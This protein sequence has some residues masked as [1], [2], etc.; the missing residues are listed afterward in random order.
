MA[1]SWNNADAMALCNVIIK[2]KESMIKCPFCGGKRF[3]F[4]AEK[5]IGKCFQC[6][7]SADT[8]SYYAAT[9]N[10]SL[11]EARKEIEGRL[12]IVSN[13]NIEKRPEKI[14]YQED[15]ANFTEREA[16]RAADEVL[17]R[18]YRAFLEKLPLTEKSRHLLLARGF[19]EDEITSLGY[20][21]FPNKEEVN[22][23]DI[24]KQLQKEGCILEGVPGFFKCKN[25]NYTFRQ[26]KEGIVM[27][28]KDYF[29]RITGLQIRKYDD[30]R[31]YLD[32]EERME[33][34]CAWFSSADR[35]GGCG[36]Q[37]RVHYACDFKFCPEDQKWRPVH[38]KGFLLTEGIMKGDITHFLQPNLPVIA[39]PGVHAL[40]YLGT[41]LKR[42]KKAG[43][44]VIL[45]AYDMDYQTNPNVQEALEN[46]RKLIE[47]T[48]LRCKPFT[49]ET[50]V[51][52][53]GESHNLLKGIDD[54]L[55]YVKL[56]IVP[57][58]K[59]KG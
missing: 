30:L 6:N 41:E 24:C 45:L 47:Q 53:D 52:I 51:V 37:A 38:Q 32:D 13:R 33:G 2:R 39:V 19:S 42:L 46:T 3:G 16:Q 34:K 58:I 9:Y 22:F 28:Q 20:K 29:N 11:N 23:F 15:G 14:V 10:M 54:Y 44:E 21:T 56:G 40:N 1:Y 36:A 17:D 59:K 7:G 35:N 31:V 50:N 57:Q 27:P 49:W 8:A 43:V 18:T 48:G 12:G 25:G 5:G 4:N 26:T 55:A